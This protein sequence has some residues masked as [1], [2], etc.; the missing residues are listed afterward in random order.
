MKS[1][2]NA[3]L[4]SFAFASCSY[5]Q[6]WNQGSGPNGNFIVES[7][8]PPPEWSVV[9]EK[10][11]QWRT[12]LPELGQSSIVAWNDRLFFTIN[13][14]VE[15]DAKLGKDIIAYCCDADT[16]EVLWTRTIEGQYP[17]KIASSFGDSSGPAPVVDGES[18]V[19]FNSG[20]AIEAFDLDGQR[21]WRREML[22][23]NRAYPILS[24]NALLFIQVN[25]TPDEK[26]GYPHP[27]ETPPLSEW[28]Q[29]VAIDIE[30][31]NDLWKTECGANMGSIPLMLELEDGSPALLVGRGGGH[32]PPE[33]PI[34]V[35]LVDARDGSEIWNLPIEDFNSTM[36]KPTHDGHALIFHDSEHWWI[37]LK[38][39]EVVRKVSILKDVSVIEWDCYGWAKSTK[40]LS[41]SKK[42][43]E[44]TQQSN[45]L[46]GDYHYF[47]SYTENYL[48]RVNA[49]T[50]KV[51]YLQ[52]PVSLL[53]MEGE[54]DRLAWSKGDL[55]G[56]ISEK[57]PFNVPTEPSF[58]NFKLN[59]MRNA[60]GHLVMGD[61]RSQGN[62]WGHVAAPIPTVVGDT[63]YVPVMNGLVYAIDWS[64]EKLDENALIAINDLGELGESWTRSSLT[65]ANGKL[66]ARTIKEL[67]CIGE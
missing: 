14:P 21:L 29:L 63:L 30:N 44:I 38:S 28:T 36:T 54:T 17:L 4:C 6:N 57:K 34:G 26:G 59:A 19:F 60:N 51:E 64:V 22:L 8:N 40:T 61:P 11:I 53:R 65:Y 41:G 16:G 27:K 18:V 46:V 56:L 5:A 50:G 47:R 39:G 52:L 35:S 25:A 32:S 33:R 3:L 45:L 43:R 10:N 9:L 23:T 20:G 58:W 13:R 31:G 48:G 42:P 55:E 62:G 2:A 66:Y 7:G 67:I 37:D 1:L 49:K 12:E 24:G 15:S